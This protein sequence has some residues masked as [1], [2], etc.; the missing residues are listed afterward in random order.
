[1]LNENKS[2]LEEGDP[3][4]E[5]CKAALLPLK[6]WLMLYPTLL[7]K[8]LLL[9]LLW[10]IPKALKIAQALVSVWFLFFVLY[11]QI[12]FKGVVKFIE[13]IS[14]VGLNP[15]DS[16]DNSVPSNSSTGIEPSLRPHYFY[17]LQQSC[18]RILTE[19]S[20]FVYLSILEQILY[21]DAGTSVKLF[22]T[23]LPLII[24]IKLAILIKPFMPFHMV[25]MVALL[26]S[27]STSNYV[28]SLTVCYVFLLLE[29]VLAALMSLSRRLNMTAKQSFAAGCHIIVL[30]LFGVL[31]KVW[32]R[33]VQEPFSGSPVYCMCTLG[34]TSSPP[35]Y[36]PQLYM[37][38]YEILA[39]L[40]A[41][42]TIGILWYST[43]TQFYA[44]LLRVSA[45]PVPDPMAPPNA[46]DVTGSMLTTSYA[47]TMD[48]IPAHV[49]FVR[50]EG[51]QMRRVEG[52]WK[53]V[54]IGKVYWNMMS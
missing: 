13:A 30:F 21:S 41:S 26:V 25:R 1:M 23:A 44:Q 49:L 35:V 9:I 8:I 28:C 36:M 10:R 54:M 27:L 24:L 32:M 42:C 19:A 52:Y 6:I 48:V 45:R 31:A 12:L 50:N 40:L 5:L 53:V 18:L 4:T 22:F 37:G 2:L 29:L 43:R 11:K 14:V 47:N 39:L 46:V 17:L 34:L 20:A 51:W 16:E 38:I 33:G 15:V 7:V 3:H